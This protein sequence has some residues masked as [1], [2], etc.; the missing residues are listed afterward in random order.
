MQ[1][2]VAGIVG[3]VGNVEDRVNAKDV[4]QHE[5]VKMQRMVPDHKPVVCQPAK[6]L[7]LFRDRDPLCAFDR[8]QGGKEMGDGTRAADPGQKRW[9][10]NNPPALYR[11]RKEPPVVTDNE[12]QVPYY[13]AFDKDLEASAA[14]DL[15]DGVYCY[16]STRH[17]RRYRTVPDNC[18]TSA[19]TT[20]PS[21]GT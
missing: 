19:R 18:S 10:R 12:L 20:A 2:R 1:E 5:E 14:L 3:V 15:R 13:I 9:N 6:C 16:V 21:S 17:D 8:H 11:N 7:R 4:G